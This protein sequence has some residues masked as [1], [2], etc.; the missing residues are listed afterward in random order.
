MSEDN[1]LLTRV[2][3]G[4]FARGIKNRFINRMQSYEDTV[5]DYPIQ[6]ALTREMCKEA[7][8]LNKIDFMSLWAGQAAYLCKEMTAAK[9]V[10]ELRNEII[11]LRN[12]IE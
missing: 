3:S 5:L 8:H 4:K 12:R 9:I 6:N 1:T 11:I 10:E 7:S 2:F